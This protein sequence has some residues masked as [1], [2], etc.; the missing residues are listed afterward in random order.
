MT[1][2][3]KDYLAELKDDELL[4]TNGKIFVYLKGLERLA[5]ERGIQSTAS[6]IVSASPDFAAVTYRYTFKDGTAFDGS[7]DAK[8][9]NC[10]KGFDLY[11]AAMA[12]S[13]AKSRALR[14]AFNI[15]ICSVE[16]ISEIAGEAE[17]AKDYQ[18][19]NI[20]LMMESKS[21][22]LTRV[23]EW[24]KR[25][26]KDLKELT[27]DEAILVIGKLNGMRKDATR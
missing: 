15:T 10:K 17:P 23:G 27:R 6:H 9:S 2:E 5:H 26:L 14:T 1:E 3:V 12:E 16:E 18:L 25:K 4:N 11:L 13:R 20:K 8:P 22:E 7:A 21:V 19:Q 24:T